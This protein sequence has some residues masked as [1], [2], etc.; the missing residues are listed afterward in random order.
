MTALPGAADDKKDT[1]QIK[2]GEEIVKKIEE[3]M[4]DLASQTGLKMYYDNEAD[5][6]VVTITNSRTGEVVRQIPSSDF[7]AFVKRLKQYA[8]LLVD[9]RV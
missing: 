4:D 8:G 7:L 5:R 2:T 3:I 1:L 9:R 6:V